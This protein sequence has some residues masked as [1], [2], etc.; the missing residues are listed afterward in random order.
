MKKFDRATQEGYYDHY[1]VPGHRWYREDGRI[2]EHFHV[3]FG[4]PL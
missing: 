1:H 4:D 2:F 3:W